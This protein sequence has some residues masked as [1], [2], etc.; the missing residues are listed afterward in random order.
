MCLPRQ[1]LPDI[2]FLLGKSC[3]YHCNAKP[4]SFIKPE[5]TAAV[6]RLPYTV[7]KKTINIWRRWTM[8]SLICLHLYL[9][10]WTVWY[11]TPLLK[12]VEYF[13]QSEC[14][15]L[16][17]WHYT[18]NVTSEFDTVK[19]WVVTAGIFHSTAAIKLFLNTG[20]LDEWKHLK[21]LMCLHIVD[22]SLL[23]LKAK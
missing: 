21:I 16:A 10:L 19:P 4:N 1:T 18:S 22:P 13:R 2:F 9:S 11:D 15:K 6:N 3:K 17:Y 20:K 8:L 7:I 14:K 12:E 23:W 5:E